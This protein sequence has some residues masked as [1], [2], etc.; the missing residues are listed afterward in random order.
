MDDPANEFRPPF[1]GPILSAA[2][3][4]RIIA[5]ASWPLILLGLYPAWGVVQMAFD[6]KGAPVVIILVFALLTASFFVPPILL[7]TTKSPSAA[8][9]VLLL[10]LLI[11]FFSVTGDWALAELVGAWALLA[12]LLCVIL[13]IQAWRALQAAKALP[14]LQSFER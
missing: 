2:Q 11:T 14:R 10:S 1:W 5:L 12:P 4:R 7:L 6:G 8:T 9:S 3:A 13:S